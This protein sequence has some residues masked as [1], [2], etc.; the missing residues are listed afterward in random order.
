MRKFLWVAV[1]AAWM[2]SG[3]IFFSAQQKSGFEKALV[4]ARSFSTGLAQVSVDTLDFANLVEHSLKGAQFPN[5]L[6]QTF[7]GLHYESMGPD[8]VLHSSVARTHGQAY[9]GDRTDWLPTSYRYR[10][11]AEA[12]TYSIRFTNF[13][14][15]DFL[16]LEQLLIVP[17]DLGRA[18]ELELIAHTSLDSGDTIKNAAMVFGYDADIGSPTGGYGDDRSEAILSD[19][20]ELLYAFDETEDLFTGFS[21]SSGGTGKNPGNMLKFH[22]TVNRS[23]ASMNIVDSVLLDMMQSPQF[24]AGLAAGDVSLYWVVSLGS[25]ADTIS[26][27]VRFTLVN[28][29]SRD[30]IRNPDLSKREVENDSEESFSF[31]LSKNFPNPFNPTTTI[32]YRLQR[33]AVVDLSV[34]NLLGQKVRTLVNGR[35]TGGTHVL[36][37]D[38]KNDEGRVVS[39]G[40]YF[41]RLQSDRQSITRKMMFL[42]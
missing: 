28:G 16:E 19:S 29:R 30:D 37:W 39:T 34:F 41:Y 17:P 38:G 9:P 3:F 26:D 7:F 4:R 18:I 2:L 10:S 21:Y 23:G 32:T 14:I 11:G 33:D 40:V 24:D 8:S 36:I 42:K 27:T 31:E 6:Y 20:L 12:D 35:V 5:G 25:Y 22:Q 15:I 1:S 13:E